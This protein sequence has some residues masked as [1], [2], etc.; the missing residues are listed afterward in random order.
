ML[1]SGCGAGCLGHFL[2]VAAGAFSA[3]AVA[4]ITAMIS[5]GIV[6]PGARSCSDSLIRH[7]RLRRQEFGFWALQHL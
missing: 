4:A 1:T 5:E 2:V 3:A 6:C 7:A